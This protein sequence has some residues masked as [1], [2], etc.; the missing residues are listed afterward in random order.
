M[1]LKY[2]L[3]HHYFYYFSILLLCCRNQILPSP[4]K[5]LF[6]SYEQPLSDKQIQ[7]LYEEGQFFL[8]CDAMKHGEDELA[9]EQF[10]QLNMA[11]A[12][13]YQAQ[14]RGGQGGGG[15][16]PSRGLVLLVQTNSYRLNQF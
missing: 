12:S 13:Y 1:C 10:E 5:R 2:L 8:A 11:E 3:V 6:A 9:V 7:D 15:L 14:V 16:L 4:K